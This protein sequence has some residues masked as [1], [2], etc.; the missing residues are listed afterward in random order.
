MLESKVFQQ[1]VAASAKGLGSQ[2][3]Q[4]PQQA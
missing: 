2:D 3:K 4:E 1:Q